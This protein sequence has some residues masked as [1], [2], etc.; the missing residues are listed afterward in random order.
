MP[1][2]WF[3]IVLRSDSHNRVWPISSPTGTSDKSTGSGPL[4]SRSGSHLG[5]CDEIHLMTQS[6][7]KPR[8]DIVR[9]NTRIER[10]LEYV[11][12]AWRDSPKTPKKRDTN[13]VAKLAD[14]N[15]NQKFAVLY[16]E[17][18]ASGQAPV[19]NAA[20]VAATQYNGCLHSRKTG[21]TMR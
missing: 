6:M 21:R 7:T 2:R 16:A 8:C 20:R 17:H 14:P 19:D 18:I 11:R 12:S 13:I 10:N 5:D 15:T 9:R 3:K 4:F 1:C